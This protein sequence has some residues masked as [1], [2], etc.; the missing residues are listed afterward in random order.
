MDETEGFYTLKGY[1]LKETAEM[2][3]TTEDYP[4][5]ITRVALSSRS[6]HVGELSKSCTARLHLLQK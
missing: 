4:E 3:D 1:S 2:R 5:M 6:V